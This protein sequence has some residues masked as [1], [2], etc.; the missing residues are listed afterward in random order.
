MDKKAKKG[1]Y[2]DILLRSKK[3][4][5][6]TEDVALLW[7]EENEGAARVRLSYYVKNGKLIRIRRGLYAK[8]DHYDRFELATRIYTPSYISF[9]TVLTRS[10]I[11]F[12]YYSTIFVAS[13]VSREIE[14]A[15]QKITFVRM[16]NYVLSN[17]AGI[18][19][20]TGY[21]IATKERAFLDRIYVSK[22]YHFDHLDPLDWDKV[23]QI[24]PAYNNKRIIK[25]VNEYFKHYKDAK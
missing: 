25:K 18:E 11:N 12:Q 23:F 13:Y 21:A 24:L 9:E 3:T 20:K 4:I 8:D 16:K 14:I 19:H 2:L 15:G 5:F 22:D 6:S 17:T 7:G 10:G 1:E